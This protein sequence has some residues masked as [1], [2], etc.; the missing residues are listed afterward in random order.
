MLI[1]YFWM[2]N[3]LDETVK[4]KAAAMQPG[5]SVHAQK[6]SINKI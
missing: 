4:I 6:Y 1:D 3:N 2:S 5:K